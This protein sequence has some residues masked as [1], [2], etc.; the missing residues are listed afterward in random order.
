MEYAGKDE[1]KAPFDLMDI[2]QGQFALVKLPFKEYVIDDPVYQRRNSCRSW[3]SED[4]RCS[5]DTICHH[6]KGSDTGLG[7]WPWIPVIFF[8]RRSTLSP[9]FCFLIKIADEHGTV[10]LL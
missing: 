1:R 3:I 6:D 5:F 8:S 2:L 4:P 7:L 9:L 10:V